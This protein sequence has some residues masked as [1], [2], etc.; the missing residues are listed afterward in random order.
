[1][2]RQLQHAH[3]HDAVTGT[4]TATNFAALVAQA[5]ERRQ[6]L[7]DADQAGALLV[8]TVENLDEIG[9]RYGPEWG[10]T[11]M[12]AL[13][14]I[15]RAAIRQSDVVGR[16]ATNEL[17]VLLPGAKEE[18]AGDI[19]ARI[20]AGIDRASFAGDGETPIRVEIALGGVLFEAPVEF[21]RM[22]RSASAV[23][24]A[25]HAGQTVP[26]HHAQP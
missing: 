15:V 5:N 26:L 9:R 3:R 12:Q 1:M 17:G 10:D 16:L 23:A 21:N 13:A 11:V 2:R 18:N 4:L 25:G 22:R 19:G 6:A 8:V 14:S 24:S 20:R 7:S